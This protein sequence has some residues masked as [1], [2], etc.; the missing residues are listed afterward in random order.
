MGLTAR[1]VMPKS[2][3]SLTSMLMVKVACAPAGPAVH[4]TVLLPG[5]SSRGGMNCE[6]DG[7]SHDTASE[8]PSRVAFTSYSTG[9]KAAE[10]AALMVAVPPSCTDIAVGERICI[11]ENT[12]SA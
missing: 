3:C 2:A 12:T 1:S 5:P 8:S 11:S 4:V 9:M 10:P 6:P 7:G